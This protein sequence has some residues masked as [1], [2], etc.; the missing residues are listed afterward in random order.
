MSGVLSIPP[1]AADAQ[2]RS[3]D[4]GASV[5]VSANAGAGKTYVLAQRVVRL[6][7]GPGLV[8]LE[9]S[10]HFD[11]QL[12]TVA[13]N[14]DLDCPSDALGDEAVAEG[15]RIVDRLSGDRQHKISRPEAGPVGRTVVHDPG[16]QRAARPI[17]PKPNMRW[18]IFNRPA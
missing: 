8:A 5:W 7:P 11:G 3:S 16:H 13:E 4:P 12:P 1:E 14:G 10:S 17:E 6:Q 18:R 9:P 2:H 15:V